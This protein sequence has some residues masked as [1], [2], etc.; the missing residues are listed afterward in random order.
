MADTKQP[1]PLAPAAAPQEDME[2]YKGRVRDHL[3]ELRDSFTRDTANG[4]L[5]RW[6]DAGRP[7]NANPPGEPAG[8]HADRPPDY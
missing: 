6:P 5:F 2:A 8:R 4:G 3:A 1:E 7:A